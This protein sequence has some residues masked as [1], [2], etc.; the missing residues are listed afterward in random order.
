V[1]EGG[2]GAGAGGG[3]LR[4][5]ER[6]RPEG[7][8]PTLRSSAELVVC[9]FWQNVLF[10]GFSPPLMASCWCCQWGLAMLGCPSCGTRP[11]TLSR[12]HDDHHGALAVE[13]LALALDHGPP[14]SHMPTSRQATCGTLVLGASRAPPPVQCSREHGYTSLDPLGP[15]SRCGEHVQISKHHLQS[16]QGSQ[17]CNRERNPPHGANVTVRRAS[18]TPPRPPGERGPTATYAL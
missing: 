1:E 5:G 17:P 9:M 2:G 8:G 3:L 4:P 7:R 14:C 18:N 16:C 11:L 12:R 15:G 6:E 13:R 10:V